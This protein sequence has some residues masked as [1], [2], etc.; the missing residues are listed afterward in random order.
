MG[1]LTSNNTHNFLIKPGRLPTLNP[2]PRPLRH[3]HAYSHCITSEIENKGSQVR[4]HG[5]WG[6]KSFPFLPSRQTGCLYY[7]L[8]S[9][10]R[11]CQKMNQLGLPFCHSQHNKSLF[12]VLSFF[13]IIALSCWWY[14]YSF[15]QRRSTYFDY[16]FFRVQKYHAQ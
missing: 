3:S 4:G 6:A 1:G 14:W 12:A 13:C 2:S 10:C 16:S 11:P 8:F 5:Q 9:Y 15:D 7:A